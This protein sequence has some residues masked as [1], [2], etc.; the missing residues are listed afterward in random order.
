M[1]SFLLILTFPLTMTTFELFAT[2]TGTGIISSCPCESLFQGQNSHYFRGGVT[3]AY[4]PGKNL[5]RNIDMMEEGFPAL[6][7]IV[8]A[9]FFG[10]SGKKSVFGTFPS[11]GE[12]H[13]TFTTYRR[14]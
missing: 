10:R 3:P 7:E 11:T 2:S 8:Q 1:K 13:V 6:T 14:Q 4:Q 9:R 5:H 12:E